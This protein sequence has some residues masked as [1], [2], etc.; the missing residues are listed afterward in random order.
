M[1]STLN[2]AILIYIVLIKDCVFKNGKFISH[3][4]ISFI[5]F[6]VSKSYI[7]KNSFDGCTKFVGKISYQAPE[8]YHKKAFNAAKAD[9]WSLGVILFMILFFG[10]PY[11]APT[12][13]DP[14][15][16]NICGGFIPEWA[17]DNSKT[18]FLSKEVLGMHACILI[19]L[20]F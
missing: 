7:N 17:K 11:N 16:N 2:I 5:D 14:M 15:F 6:G 1:F 19:I 8:I 18:E 10:C 20:N 12:N 4:V 3:G 13:A 9:V